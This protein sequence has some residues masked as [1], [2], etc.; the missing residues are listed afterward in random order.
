M[1]RTFAIAFAAI[2]ILGVAVAE[3]RLRMLRV[4]AARRATML[5]RT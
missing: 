4:Y 2:V 1:T 5:R 3:G